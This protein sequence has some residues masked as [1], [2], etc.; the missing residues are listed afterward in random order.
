M[1]PFPIFFWFFFKYSYSF[2]ADFVNS[3]PILSALEQM[4]E[5]TP[6]HPSEAA[7]EWKEDKRQ[8]E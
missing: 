1:T 8:E 2:S 7:E 4:E 6:L 5:L 3:Q